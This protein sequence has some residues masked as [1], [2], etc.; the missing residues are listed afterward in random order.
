MIVK[1]LRIFNFKQYKGEQKIKFSTDKNRN[2]TVIL[3]GNS[4]GKTNLLE[5]LKWCSFDKDLAPERILNINILEGME[6]RSRERVYVEFDFIFNNIEYIYKKSREFIKNEKG[7]IEAFEIKKE[8]IYMEDNVFKQIENNKIDGIIKKA[9]EGVF[10]LNEDCFSNINK[11]KNII[12]EI[13]EKLSSL[14]A[15]S[16]I[17]EE[18]KE[19]IL[20]LETPFLRTDKEK[21]IDL[22]IQLSGLANQVILFSG[23]KEWE[24]T[25]DAIKDKIGHIYKLD[26][27]DTAGTYSKIRKKGNNL[28]Q[29]ATSELS[30]DAIIAWICNNYN[31]KLDN[32]ELYNLANEI[33]RIL[34]GD[35]KISNIESLRIMRQFKNIDLLLVVNNKYA[36][37][38]E[39]KTYTSEHGDQLSRYKEIIMDNKIN[40]DLGHWPHFEAEDIIT[41]YLKT[42]FHY[43]I[44]MEVEADYKMTGLELYNILL[45]YEGESEI[46]NDYILKLE[47]D[48][49]W[50]SNIEDKYHAGW[51]EPTLKT[52]YG[53]YLLLKDMFG[54]MVD[55]AH[56]SSYG[57]PWSNHVIEYIPYTKDS[58]TNISYGNYTI[59]CRIDKKND[60]Y[61]ASIR[62]YDQ[63]L[64]KKNSS[65][66]NQKKKD[67][68]KLC[69]IFK[70][71]C[72]SIKKLKNDS[73]QERYKLGGNNGGYFESE[74]GVF[75]FGD[76]R[77]QIGIEEFPEIFQEFLLK[78]KSK[79]K[80][81]FSPPY[82]ITSRDSRVNTII[83]ENETS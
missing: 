73:G 58:D 77:D 67:F 47:S 51:V 62:Q 27:I 48:L 54:Q 44:D 42:G 25:R 23:N 64:D 49:D 21:I 33:I 74:F 41:V 81:E 43:P 11:Q 18:V 19:N 7:N 55:F 13:K 35:K 34:L 71:T 9:V 14:T 40:Q 10:I 60:L 70:E 2:M 30:Q 32:I 80:K 38:I 17:T 16:S 69:N 59:F 39:D 63:N 82:D 56:G 61:Y 75:F 26:K 57:R 29:F 6:N 78:F 83:K 5:A 68:Y 72:D 8:M 76:D 15:S 66:V 20:F 46:L 31:Y 65:M 79:L 45:K 53:Q 3:G 28:F 52:Y 22:S 1:E 36:I 37:I 12:H 50:Y 4:S 24:H